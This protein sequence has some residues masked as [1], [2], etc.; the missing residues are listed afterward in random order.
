MKNSLSLRAAALATLA[1][2]LAACDNRN[3]NN[4]SGTTSA[5][6]GTSTASGATG[7]LVVQESADIPTLDPGTTYDTSSGQV[8][9]NLYE[10][11]LT[12]QGSSLSDLR[13]LL[14]T[15]WRA[16]NDGREYRFTLREGV[17]FHSGNDFTCAD[18]EYT[19][20]R[21]LV[22]NTSD[23]GNWFLSESLLGTGSNANDDSSITWER[24]TNAV[25]CDGGTLVFTLPKVD[26]A[27]LSKLAYTGQSIVDSEHAKKIGEW[28]GTEATW[29]AAVGQDLTGSPLAQNP[30]GTGAYRFL[31]KTSSALTAEAF[32][33]YWGEKA[34]IK[35]VI[36]QVVPEQAARQQAFLRGDADLIETGGRP[37]VEEQLRGQPGVAVLDDLPDI[38]AFGISMNQNIK[39]A[40]L[41]GSGQLNGQGIPANFFSDVDVRRGFVASFD[42]PTYIEE[43]QGGKGEARNFL[44]PDTFPGYDQSLAAPEFNLD[45]ARQAF[46]RAWGGRVWQQGF[47][48]TATY[49]AGSVPAQTAMEL[50]KRNIESLNPK[51]RVNIQSKQWSEILED[52]GAGREVMIITGWAPDYADADNFVHTFYASDGYYQPRLNFKDAQIDGWIGEARTITDAERR[53]EL[54]GQVARRALDQAYYVLMP[55]NPGILAYRDNLQGISRETFNPM[56][57]FRTGTYWKDLSKS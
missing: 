4:N 30:S 31:Q 39:D 8:V 6:G 43:V 7:T 28:D 11:L 18:A 48:L 41:L 25:K 55:S 20:R 17:K 38:S 13:P 24:I 45:A 16:A 46:Q 32:A 3:A 47:T 9:E 36:I 27:F 49:R 40:S 26:P 23:S 5:G 37:I 34:K 44:L 15:E 14:A 33:D 21:N 1:L 54:Y 12:Y 29:K 10:T 2:A 53:N 19:F 22:T 50:L 51:F 35:N 57:A 52:G 56:L 42:V